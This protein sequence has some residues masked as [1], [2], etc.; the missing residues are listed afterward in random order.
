M[1]SHNVWLVPYENGAAIGRLKGTFSH[2]RSTP[3]ERTIASSGFC[4]QVE[5]AARARSLDRRVRIAFEMFGAPQAPCSRTRA[6]R[7]SNRNRR[8]LATSGSQR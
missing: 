8:S 3:R 5:P 1:K 2:A 4:Q 6:P 7:D